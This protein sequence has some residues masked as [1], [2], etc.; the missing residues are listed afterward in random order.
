MVSSPLIQ[1]IGQRH[2]GTHARLR[3]TGE[4]TEHEESSVNLFSCCGA[5]HIFPAQQQYDELR[6]DTIPAL[7]L[8]SGEICAPAHAL[9]L[10]QQPHLLLHHISIVSLPQP[11][12]A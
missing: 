2:P 6:A 3:F 12:T 10:G 9:M 1:C 7:V 8:R 11:Y 4:G 5:G